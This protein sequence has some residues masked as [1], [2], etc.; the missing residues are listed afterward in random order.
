MDDTNQNPHTNSQD[1]AYP[2]NPTASS[3]IGLE[4]EQPNEDMTEEPAVFVDMQDAVEVQVDDNDVPMDDEDQDEAAPSDATSV[5]D[6]SKAKVESHTGPVYSVAAHYDST[7][8][9]ILSGGGDDKSFLH[10][11][12]PGHAPSTLLLAH[13]HSDTVSCVA[14]NNPYVSDDLSKTPKLAAV[15][16][17]DGAIVLYDPDT[18]SKLKE[19]EGP[20]DVEWL[21]FHP[22]GGSVRY[23]VALE[24]GA[25]CASSIIFSKTISLFVYRFYWLALYQMGPFGCIIFPHPSVCKCL[26]DTRVV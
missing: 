19:L 18:G 3:I 5:Q 7:K 13:A 12:V 4:E 25:F 6:M 20:S 9:L 23:L 8:L 14:F 10:Q 11:I 24:S 1:D 26:W 21:C 17:Y 22:K 15:G 16:G 2:D